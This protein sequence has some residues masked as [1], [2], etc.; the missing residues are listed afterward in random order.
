M[1]HVH[2]SRPDLQTLFVN[3]VTNIVDMCDIADLIQ[4]L[5]SSRKAE[6]FR[7]HNFDSLILANKSITD[8]TFRRTFTKAIAEALATVNSRRIAAE[9]LA[10][11]RNQTLPKPAG[12]NPNEV[13]LLQGR[14]NEFI[15]MIKYSDDA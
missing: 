4:S 15:D 10:K 5:P 12:L 6:A 14:L 1:G 8:Q 13:A 2:L 11:S 9:N 3:A 7:A